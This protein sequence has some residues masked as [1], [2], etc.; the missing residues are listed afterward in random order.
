MLSMRNESNE[1][2]LCET[3]VSSLK[4]VKD[5][6]KVFNSNVVM[7]LSN[8]ILSIFLPLSL[9]VTEYGEYRQYILYISYIAI[10]NLGYIDGIFIKYG[11]ENL[12]YSKNDLKKEHRFLVIFQFIVTVILICVSII[13]K[14]MLFLLLSLSIV[15]I[16]VSGFHKMLY[17][18]TGLF[19]K[20]SRVNIL[21][22]I[23]NLFLIGCLLLLHVNNSSYYICATLIANTLLLMIME[24]DFYKLVLGV[25]SNEKIQYSYYFKVGI[26]ILAGNFAI[27]LFNN[28]GM[29]IVNL[30]FTI[31]DFAQYSFATSML[32]MVL[33][34]VSSVGLTF[35]NYLAKNEDYKMVKF[36]TK[37]LI[38]L[39][40][41]SG[42]LFFVLKL[43]INKVLPHYSAS[44]DIIAV[45]FVN[46][47]YIMV[48]NVILINLYKARKQEKKFFLIVF[49]MLLISLILNFTSFIIFH[50]L[51][52][53]AL[54]TTISYII[55]F[56]ICT[57]IDFK[58][59]KSDLSELFMLAIHF[60]SFLLCS[61]Y[62]SWIVGLIVY[63]SII[64]ISMFIF[65]K[66]D[67][68]KLIN[69]IKKI[70]S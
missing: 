27:L 11:G 13:K 3:E 14:D 30:F 4:L 45:S 53:I 58:Y 1:N 40:I 44:L 31:E 66:K 22:T 62:L 26:F 51:T 38:I 10:F 21:F 8:I 60:I 43:F 46:L 52:L 57:N 20:Y 5:I 19:S 35:Y 32:N 69:I 18:S 33:L 50:S 25:E 42:C 16:N 68:L 7:L 49:V 56:I 55:W 48:I 63:F 6:L 36:T 47:P 64:S 12:E 59:L 67:F 39:G 70:R 15:P 29:W 23:F 28:I 41:I 17:Q 37:I 9:S 65:Y 24:Y 2:L 34:A 54:S 61:N